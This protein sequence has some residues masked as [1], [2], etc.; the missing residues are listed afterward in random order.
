M[1]ATL[2]TKTTNQRIDWGW[3]TVHNEAAPTINQYVG[4]TH[5]EPRVGFWNARQGPRDIL[6]QFRFHLLANDVAVDVQL[7]SDEPK[8]AHPISDHHDSSDN[9]AWQVIVDFGYFDAVSVATRRCNLA[10][11]SDE[12]T[13]RFR[14]GATAVVARPKQPIS[15]LAMLVVNDSTVAGLHL[16]LPDA[17]DALT[18]AFAFTFALCATGVTR[19]AIRDSPTV[20]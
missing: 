18:F 7:R 11:Q 10:D 15:G 5:L 1:G 12:L 8:R 9:P 4:R 14:G 3:M 16:R 2:A 19:P 17:V 6:G 13:L 20:D